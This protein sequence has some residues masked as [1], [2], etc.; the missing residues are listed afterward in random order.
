MFRLQ[1]VLKVCFIAMLIFLSGCDNG[2][3]QSNHNQASTTSISL[4]IDLWPGYYPIILAD[5]LGMLKKRNI[6]LELSIPRNTDRMLAKFAAAEYDAIAVALGDVMNLSQQYPD[7]RIVM[8]ADESSGGDAILAR[9]DQQVIKGTKIG[10][11]LGGFGELLVRRFL[12]A[13]D[14]AIDDVT[15]M[16][17]EVSHAAKLLNNNSIDYAHTWQPYV[18]EMV[19]GGA[20]VVYSSAQT[21]GLIPDVIAMQSAFIE[22]NHEAARGFVDAWFEAQA[23]WL[24]NPSKGNEIIARVIKQTPQ[25]IKLNGVKLLNRADNFAAF[26]SQNSAGL[27][28]VIGVYNQ[29]YVGQGIIAKPIRSER[30]LDAR[31]IQ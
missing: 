24:E 1:G 14:I 6:S 16:N 19:A 25:S 21:P 4:A 17:I 12:D 27:N 9:S 2:N 28:S 20:H 3:R 30:L 15:L 26:T 23:W 22:N 10:T 29:F 11:N 13:N 5:E 7:A 31:L 8:V 18:D